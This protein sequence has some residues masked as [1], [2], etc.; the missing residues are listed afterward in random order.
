MRLLAQTL[1]WGGA[2]SHVLLPGVPAHSSR[3]AMLSH[4]MAL[5]AGSGLACGDSLGQRPGLP[6]DAPGS[7]LK[8]GGPGPRSPSQRQIGPYLSVVMWPEAVTFLALSRECSCSLT[9]NWAVLALIIPTMRVSPES[10]WE[11]V[12][13]WLCRGQR[14]DPLTCASLCPCSGLCS[15]LSR[16]CWPPTLFPPLARLHQHP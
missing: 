15:P 9:V 10:S 3:G 6:A 2:R 7:H 13:A 11:Q 14:S 16:A 8:A 12:W 1:A 5:T 4:H